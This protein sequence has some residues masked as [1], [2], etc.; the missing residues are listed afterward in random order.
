MTT[1][2][3]AASGLMDMGQETYIIIAG[4]GSLGALAVGVFLSLKYSVK[5]GFGSG[6][7]ALFGG[8]ILSVF[9]LNAVGF[10]D[11]GVHEVRDRTGYTPSLYR[12]Q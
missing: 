12:G 2:I 7:A 6:I 10:R 5:V 4:L 11:M 1:T 8:I 9:I 3:T